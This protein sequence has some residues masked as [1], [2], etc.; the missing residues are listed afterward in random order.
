VEESAKTSSASDE[1]A[2][3][4]PAKTE[5]TGGSETAAGSQPSGG[6]GSSSGSSSGTSSGSGQG[7]GVSSGKATSATR[8]TQVLPFGA[9]MTR[10]RLLSGHDPSYTREALVAKVS[11]TMIVKCV[12]TTAGRIE[13]CRIIKGLPHMERAVLE[14]MASRHYTPVMYQGRAVAVDYVFN[15]KLVLP[16][17]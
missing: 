10:P 16:D 12:I 4:E 5:A 15:I 13:G 9:G 17:G 8:S 6:Q 7:Q 1:P 14:A 2:K 3:K 11:G